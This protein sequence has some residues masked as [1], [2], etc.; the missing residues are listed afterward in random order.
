MAPFP[1]RSVKKGEQMDSAVQP[2]A[3]LQS[4]AHLRASAKSAQSRS[5]M[6]SSESVLGILQLIFTGA[7]LAEVLAIIAQLV[8]SR[9]DGTLCT[10]WLPDDSRRQLHCA[11]APSLPGF[12][13][14]VGSML[15]G[16]QGGSCGKNN[17]T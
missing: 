16:P 10:I 4:P 8:E 5:A 1:R 6:F 14:D 9:D 3:H 17:A 7:P 2:P 12:I 11:A 13:T 15:I